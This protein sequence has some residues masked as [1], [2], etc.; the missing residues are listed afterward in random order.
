M[1]DILV[2]KNSIEN[3]SLEIKASRVSESNNERFILK[4]TKIA[5]KKIVLE[6]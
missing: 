3:L 4:L 5:C 6:I 2:T 1:D